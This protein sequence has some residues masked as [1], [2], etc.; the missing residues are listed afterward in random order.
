MPD[1]KKN[2]IISLISYAA[3]KDIP[4]AVDGICAS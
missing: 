2:L 4:V 1:Y 3:Q